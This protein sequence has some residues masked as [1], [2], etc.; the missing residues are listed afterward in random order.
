[1][2]IIKNIL[3]VLLCIVLCFACEDNKHKT[4]INPTLSV[5]PSEAVSFTA[6]GGEKTFTVTTNQEIWNV[7]SN[8]NWCQVTGKSGN[9]FKLLAKA[10]ETLSPRA[11]ATITITAGEAKSVTLTVNQAGASPVLS[12]SPNE[13]AV[14]FSAAAGEEKFSYSVSGNEVTWDVQLATAKAAWC[15][16]TK[17]IAKKTFVITAEDNLTVERREAKVRVSGDKAP[18]IVITVKQKAANP[19]LAISPDTKEIAFS[20]ATASESFSYTVSG[21]E[22]TW[23]VKVPDN[24]SWCKITK[25]ID[26]KTFTITADDN[27]SFDERETQITIS[28]E[29]ARS[30][31]IKIKQKATAPEL[32]ILPNK[33]A[34]AFSAK[35]TGESFDYK[36]TTN[37]ASWDV[38]V[39]DNAE[40]CKITKD[41]DAKTFVITAD[42]NISFDEREAKITVSGDKAVDIV[43]SVKQKGK[44]PVLTLTPVSREIAF[45]NT[46]ENESF[47]YTVTT[48][49]TGWEVEAVDW[50]K[51]TKN[52][53]SFKIK[54]K[55]NDST[56][57]RTGTIVVTSAS[58]RAAS[59]TITVKQKGKTTGDSKGFDYKEGTEWD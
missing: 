21:N 56:A 23:D 18:E 25:D 28:G 33:K 29:K 13:T 39:A 44:K 40:W 46:A 3:A 26:D 24:A 34:V 8:Q 16:I 45:S 50:C 48:N 22:A 17:D 19:V 6:E 43:I 51:I 47:N 42:D 31:I 58:G 57:E 1:M 37:E 53:T 27:S 12:I 14:T 38:Q 32:S 4:P 54:A 49:D 41:I 11:A 52:E 36:V 55:L 5:S 20:A 15:K 35:T 10:N 9:T 30:I 7:I 2:K 59:V